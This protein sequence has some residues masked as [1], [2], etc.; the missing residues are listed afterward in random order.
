MVLG[1]EVEVD[2][3]CGEVVI[4]WW[5][6]VKQGR[7]GGCTVVVVLGKKDR[8]TGSNPVLFKRDGLG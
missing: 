5:Y 1:S 3:W 6:W 4:P 8:S 7:R 2:R